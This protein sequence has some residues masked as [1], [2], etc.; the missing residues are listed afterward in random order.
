[1]NR[2]FGAVLLLGGAGLTGSLLASRSSFADPLSEAEITVLNRGRAAS[3]EPLRVEYEAPDGCPRPALFLA[4]VLRR[5]AG[6][7]AAR[8]GELARAVRVEVEERG[9]GFHGEVAI[10]LHDGREATGTF[11]APSCEQVV[12]ALSMVSAVSLRRPGDLRAPDMDL[13]DPFSDRTNGVIRPPL[14]PV[15]P[16]DERL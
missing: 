8:S 16:L 5:T 6:V 13:D 14:P 10:T 11:H 7:R 15:N 4:D 3:D 12:T 2:T 1:M 9:G